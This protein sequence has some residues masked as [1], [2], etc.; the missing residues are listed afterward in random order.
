M[1]VPLQRKSARVR[2]ALFCLLMVAILATVV[3]FG[4]AVFVGFDKDMCALLVALATLDASL[5]A[6]LWPEKTALSPEDLADDLAGTV[7]LQ[8]LE[9]VQVRRLREPGILPLTWAATGREG[10]SDTSAQAVHLGEDVRLRKLRL[11]GR[12]DGTFDDVIRQL[13]EGYQSLAEGRLV[14]LGEPG[15]GKSVLAMLL[16]LGL[17]EGRAKG[18][19][20]PVLLTASA[21]DP[22][23]ES[24]DDWIVRSLATS[25]YN[26]QE[27]TPRKLL[28]CGLLLPFLDGLDEIP[29]SAR[30]SAVQEIN[31]AVG[32][33]RPV[34]VTCR[35]VE[36]TDMIMGGAPALRRAPVVEIQTLAV[37]DVIGYLRAI[38]WPPETDWT[39][40]YEHLELVSE[41]DQVAAALSTPL[42]VSLARLVH[43]RG[44]GD[45]AKLLDRTQFA[46]R[47]SI[48]DHLIGRLVEAEYAP[49]YSAPW[50]PS[51]RFTA[52]QADRWLRFLAGHL[53]SHG[54]RDLA[55]WMLSHRLLTPW[56]APVVGIVSGAALMA[57]VTVSCYLLEE[58]QYPGILS[59][60]LTTG[61]FAGGLFAL[62]CMVIW[63]ATAGRA[64][65]RLVFSSRGSVGRLR[66]GFRNGIA[67]AA[68]PG[69]LTVAGFVVFGMA[70]GWS[71]AVVYRS[72]QIVVMTLTLLLI[73]G[74]ALAVHSWLD[75]PPERSARAGPVRYVRQDRASSLAGATAAGVTIAVL[76]FPALVPSS[77]V[78]LMLGQAVSGA[79]A[80]SMGWSR[81]SA[82]SAAGIGFSWNS[83]GDPMAI[84]AALVL[85][86]VV[87]AWLVLL[88]RAWP[89]FVVARLVLAAQGKLPMRLMDFLGDARDRGLLRQS[90]GVYQF[91]HIRFQERL[92]TRQSAGGLAP[93]FGVRPVYRRVHVPVA[94]AATAA[95]VFTMAHLTPD[96]R[97]RAVSPRS[98]L[99]L[100][101]VALNRTG[102]VVAA[103]AVG[104]VLTV[105][106]RDTWATIA[107]GTLSG[108]ITA[109][110]LSEDAKILAAA[111]GSVTYVFR[112][113]RLSGPPIAVLR[114]RADS[115]MTHADVVAI[116]SADGGDI[117]AL[118]TS[119]GDVEVWETKAEKLVATMSWKPTS[120]GRMFM[121]NSPVA[122]VSVRQHGN[123]IGVV[124]SEFTDGLMYSP[125]VRSGSR[126]VRSR[127][128]GAAGAIELKVTDPAFYTP[129]AVASAPEPLVVVAYSGAKIYLLRHPAALATVIDVGY[130]EEQ[131]GGLALSGDGR[132]VAAV[133]SG[134]AHLWDVPAV[135]L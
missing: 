113:A 109:L 67:S 83:V 7:R 87:F 62:L 36:Y 76:M 121:D 105:W 95:F 4:R 96:D 61:A 35:S 108:T 49:R 86:G 110:A 52:E 27:E 130:S 32:N 22:L 39:P 78:G 116:T 122:A 38:T 104:G 66:R 18:A 24:L 92:A 101:H 89:R 44:G 29:E 48:E 125:Y 68:I 115:P 132:V 20:T 37:P 30:R 123:W 16:V 117:W 11:R 55:W 63:Y 94:L 73:V 85:P 64:P 3:A 9:E 6:A 134:V 50:Q 40:V 23:A 54:G 111:V 97:V 133:V 59:E 45:P 107:T 126:F 102:T 34:V 41:P 12:L 71:L 14:L 10:L 88:T 5:A 43:E 131:I 80:M 114:L 93:A 70:E 57:V 13:A 28:R 17:V 74:L 91:R 33:D 129:V 58:E 15:A 56:A 99:T 135:A 46:S 25:Y 81:L 53:H 106:R 42:M 72:A 47:H 1:K 103:S 98:S 127:I 77:T 118:G 69:V 112:T 2:A 128:R 8:W 19:T 26:G 84:F 120:D 90:G 21:W 65:G 100:D 31:V 79:P 119:L 60:F 82:L 51:A 75:A 124:T